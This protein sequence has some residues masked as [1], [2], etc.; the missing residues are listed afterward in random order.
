[1]EDHADI[2]D[3]IVVLQNFLHLVHVGQVGPAGLIVG[4][5]NI[6]LGQNLQQTVTEHAVVDQQSLIALSKNRGQAGFVGGGAGTGNNDGVVAVVGVEQ[7]QDLALDG[8]EQLFELGASVADIVVQQGLTDFFLD[9]HG[10]GAKQ[11]SFHR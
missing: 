5:G 3:L 11:H 9:Q 10:A 7:L 4:G 6:V 1:M 8:H 2:G